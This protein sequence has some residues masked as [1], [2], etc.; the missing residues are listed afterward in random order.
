MRDE[1]QTG[2]TPKPVE[3][4]TPVQR[5]EVTT[6]NVPC[7]GEVGVGGLGHPR[8]WMRIA[9]DQREVTCPYCSITYALKDGAG[10]DGHH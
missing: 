4:I 7:D 5:I 8:I 2:Y 9:Q 10:D 3:G 1:R 6:R